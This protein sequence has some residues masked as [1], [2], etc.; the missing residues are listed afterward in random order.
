MSSRGLLRAMT[1]T[2]GTQAV[3]VVLSIARMKVL[4]LLLGPTGVGV[5]SLYNSLQATGTTFAGLGVDNSAVRQIAQAKDEGGELSRVRR[6]LL[7]ANL[8]QGALAMVAIWLLRAPIAAWLF[9]R[10]GY[11]F[12]VGL[13]G[14]AVFLALLG[15]S[16]T[17]LLRGMRRIGD[18]G[19]VT[20]FG[21]ARRHPGRNRRGL[22]AGCRRIAV[23][24]AAAAAHCRIWSRSLRAE[25]P[26]PPR[27]A[28][29][30]DLWRVWKPMVQLGSVF[31]LGGLQQPRRCCWCRGR[32]VGCW[33][34]MPPVSSPPPG[35]SP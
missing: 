4:A 18:L 34:S 3:S 21:R 33:G 19:R 5:L 31:M 17:A 11:E 35:A 23:V 24:R 6:V 8:V 13:V 14:V 28:P 2:G 29:A 16:Q 30:A 27:P 20:V 22:G 32:I 15:A 9:G 12:E 7:A 26:G 1:I 25:L 10:P